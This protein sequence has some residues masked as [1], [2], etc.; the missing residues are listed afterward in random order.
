MSAT[1]LSLVQR[2]PIECVIECLG[3][4]PQ[5][6]GGLGPRGAVVILKKPSRT[7]YLAQVLMGHYQMALKL[8]GEVVHWI[9]LAQDQISGRS[10]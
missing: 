10:L 7:G 8:W 9:Q 3:S 5:Q 6:R 1:G 2:D 4:K